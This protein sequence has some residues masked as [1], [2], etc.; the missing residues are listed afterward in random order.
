MSAEQKYITCGE[1]QTNLN[2]LA[3]QGMSNT[4]IEIEDFL[5]AS[6][7]QSRA[8]LTGSAKRETKFA[9]QFPTS[10]DYLLDCNANCLLSEKTES[11]KAAHT[12]VSTDKVISACEKLG[13]DANRWRPSWSHP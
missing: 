8:D 10:E 5:K 12:T 13:H 1:R 4:L 6:K 7:S 3:R 9:S 2:D 11:S